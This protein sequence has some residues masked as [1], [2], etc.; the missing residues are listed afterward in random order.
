MIPRTVSIELVPYQ[1]PHSVTIE[2]VFPSSTSDC[3]DCGSVNSDLSQSHFP[4]VPFTNVGP[5]D[6]TEK[7]PEASEVVPV[8][9]DGELEL[10][11]LY[12]IFHIA[13]TLHCH[14]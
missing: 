8:S 3:H 6:V 14:D 5:H 1:V 11:Q 13:S 12:L 2:L 10:N 4:V 7:G 9:L